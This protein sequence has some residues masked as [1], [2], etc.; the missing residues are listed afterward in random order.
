M[1]SKTDGLACLVVD[2]P[3]E[4]R[5]QFEVV[6]RETVAVHTISRLAVD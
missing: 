6:R 2:E 1:T 5:G 4:T 3:G